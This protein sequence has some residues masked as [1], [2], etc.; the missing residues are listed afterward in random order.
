MK[1]NLFR[2]EESEKPIHPCYIGTC[3]QKGTWGVMAVWGEDKQVDTR[4]VC[5]I[6]LSCA[7]PHVRDKMNDAGFKCC[8]DYFFGNACPKCGDEAEAVL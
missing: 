6:H 8:D 1:I 4:W 5:D 7:V 3:E 2:L